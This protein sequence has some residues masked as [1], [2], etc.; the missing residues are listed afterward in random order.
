MITAMFDRLG[1]LCVTRPWRVLAF[2][3][4]LVVSVLPWILHLRL[5]ADVRDT[6]PRDIAQAMERRNALFGTFDLAFILVQAPEAR[7]DT[8]LAFGAALQERLAP[9]GLIR[10]VE[11]G[12]SAAMLEALGTLTLHYAPLLVSPEQLD[13]FDRLLTPEGIQAQIRKTLAQLSLPGA[14]PQDTLLAEDPLQMRRFAFARLSALRGAFRFDPTSPYL[15]SQD[16]TALLIK[17]EGRASVDD[18]AGA[19]ATVALLQQVCQELIALPAFQDLTWQATGGYFFAAESERII[20]RD[21]T[22]SVNL[23]IV[24][25]IFLQVWVLRRWGVVVYGALPTLLGLWLALGTFAALRPQLNALTL[26]CVASLIGLGDDFT[27]H[28]LQQCFLEQSHGRARPEA[29]RTAIRDIGGGLYMAALTTMAGF[30]SFLAAG[31]PFLRDMGL[32]AALGIGWCLALGVTLLPALLVSL[33]APAHPVPPRSMGIPQLITGVLRVPRL[34][35]GLSLALSLGAIGALVWWPPGFE[36]DLRNIHAT[37]SPTLRVQETIAALFGG[38]QEPLTLM[39]TGET[40]EQVIR[41]LRRVEPALKDLVT[42]GLLAAVTSPTMLYPDPHVPAEVL[43]RLQA[44]DA[45]QLTTVLTTSLA[46]AGFDVAALQGYISAIQHALTLREPLDLSTFRARGFDPLLRPFLAHDA[47]GAVGLAVLF[48]AQDLW[49]QETR[50]TLTQRLTA[51]LAA[52]GVHGTLNSLYTISSASAALISA[53]F[54][55]IT[56]LAVA[57]VVLCV[58]LQ[59][60]RLLLVL[61]VLLPVSCGALWTAG[62]FALSGFKLNFMNIAILPMLLGIGI[63]YG[64]YVVHHFQRHGAASVSAAL[65]G[66]GTAISL[67]ALTTLLAFGTLALSMNQGIASIGVIT[68]VGITACLVASLCTL[69]AMLQVGIVGRRGER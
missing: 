54:R 21:M 6:L 29:L 18:M 56:L 44:K 26:G 31:Q 30:A 64:I 58:S 42:E 69:P 7:R 14:G 66:T 52:Q 62:F 34:I 33:P 22:S 49:T 17:I 5:E 12:Y 65:T 39:I 35:L 47:A 37:S 60:R 57:G 11:F 68:F 24:C 43:S 51:V 25:I 20:R 3:A 2:Y 45:A 55:R 15:L 1:A 9:S 4:V 40:E 63:N 16:G 67:G 13:D 27:V 28:V 19:K 10:H 41:D 38:S 48:P 36:T 23:S 46:E 53:D 61:M 50:D 32:L 59:V 8:L